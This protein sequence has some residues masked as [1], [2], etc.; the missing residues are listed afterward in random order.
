MTRIYIPDYLITSYIIF[1]Y[2]IPHIL[3]PHVLITVYNNAGGEVP[4]QPDQE[5]DGVD[6]C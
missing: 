5:V 3:I 2:L 1:S 4:E 6:E